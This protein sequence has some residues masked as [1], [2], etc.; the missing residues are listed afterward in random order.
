MYGD[1]HIDCADDDLRDRSGRFVITVAANLLP[2]CHERHRIRNDQSHAV[3]VEH[4]IVDVDRRFP[5]HSRHDLPRGADPV[6]SARNDSEHSCTADSPVAGDLVLSLVSVSSGTAT[7]PAA[8]TAGSTIAT[9]VRTAN[10]YVLSASGA[11]TYGGTWTWGTSNTSA[12]QT[13]S[14]AANTS[15]V[16]AAVASNNSNT[17]GYQVNVPTGTVNGDLLIGVVASDFGTFAG[18]A[19]GTGWTELT[20]SEYNGG[21]NAFHVG[22]WARVRPRNPRPTRC[23]T[24]ALTPWVRSSGSPAGTQPRVSPEQ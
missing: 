20:T 7:Q 13:V 8:Y 19:L 10:A 9:N 3:R 6:R 22:L 11:S 18:N 16:V 17:A 24:T 15:P 14:F 23:R 1:E 21:T 5:R 2:V 4:G 12:L